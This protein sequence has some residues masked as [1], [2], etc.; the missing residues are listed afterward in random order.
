MPHSKGGRGRTW[1]PA[2]DAAIREAA[3]RTRQH[4][5]TGFE[6]GDIQAGRRHMDDPYRNELRQVARQIGRTYAAVRQR[7]ARIGARSYHRRQVNH[8]AAHRHGSTAP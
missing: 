6:L 5:I 4:G 1:T 8:P 3:A 7:A 2:E